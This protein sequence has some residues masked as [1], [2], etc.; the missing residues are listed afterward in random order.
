MRKFAVLIVVLVAFLLAVGS[1]QASNISFKTHDLTSPLYSF[2]SFED[3]APSLSDNTV[4]GHDDIKAGN[5]AGAEDFIY[6]DCIDANVAP[7]LWVGWTR[8]ATVGSQ[9]LGQPYRASVQCAAQSATTYRGAGQYTIVGHMHAVSPSGWRWYTSGSQMQSGVT[10]G[11]S[12]YWQ[13]HIGDGSN[14]VTIYVTLWERS[15]L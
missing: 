13:A 1:A 5:E 15:N 14:Y 4:S 2:V 8:L 12:G 3:S 7:E 6:T 9:W 10:Y 11:T